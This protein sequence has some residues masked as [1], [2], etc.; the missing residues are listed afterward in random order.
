MSFTRM[1]P[2]GDCS[3][4]LGGRMHATELLPQGDR[5]TERARSSV[6]NLGL[7]SVG[8][9]VGPTFVPLSDAASG[10]R[11]ARR[12][13]ARSPGTGYAAR[14]SNSL[15]IP[16]SSIS[17]DRSSYA[18]ASSSV[19][20]ATSI[21]SRTLAA[22]SF[23][24]VMN[25]RRSPRVPPDRNGDFRPIASAGFADYQGWLRSGDD[26]GDDEWPDR[27]TSTS[28][29]CTAP[30]GRC[31]SRLTRRRRVSARPA[32]G[33]LKCGWASRRQ[34]RP[35]ASSTIDSDERADTDGRMQH[36]EPCPALSNAR[37]RHSPGRSGAPPTHSSKATSASEATISSSSRSPRT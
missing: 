6:R 30:A 26:G 29:R 14:R 5:V 8:L 23:M 22:S 13:Q 12:R 15:R 24:D 34:R 2:C 31:P 27:A 16:C 19:R 9:S 33:H 11:C 4:R 32:R 18:R 35:P 20:R 28:A 17:G 37:A 1:S 7:R 10:G 3:G 21:S 36:C 25:Q